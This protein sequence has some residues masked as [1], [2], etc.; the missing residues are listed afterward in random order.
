MDIGKLPFAEP[1]RKL[2]CFLFPKAMKKRR[3]KKWYKRQAKDSKK[4]YE[5]LAKDTAEV[6]L[7]FM[8]YGYAPLNPDEPLT[9]LDSEDEPYRFNI[10]LYHHVVGQIDLTGLNVLEI[11]SGRGGGSYYIMKYL[12]PKKVLGVDLCKSAVDLSNGTCCLEGLSF[13]EGDA[14]ALPFD[15]SSFDVVINVESS[16]CYPNLG[17]F[18]QEVHRVLLPDGYFLYADFGDETRMRELRQ[19][20][21]QSK[22][23]LLESTDI[24][25]NVI[26]AMT[27]DNERRETFLSQTF[28][29]ERY[30]IWAKR[31][32]LV[33]TEGYEAFCNQKQFYR[34]FMLQKQ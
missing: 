8:N 2:A 18:Y 17:K 1:G 4:M 5:R 33:G 32:Q 9:K 25:R 28:N 13:Q 14:E 29:E 12:N 30:Q 27:L 16:H 11:G 7:L 19:R 15:D 3:S 20:L 23:I 22:M 10:Q 21:K 26:E 6:P 31:A 34:S 24:T